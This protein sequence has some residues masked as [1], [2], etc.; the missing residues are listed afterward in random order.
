MESIGNRT[1]THTGSMFTDAFSYVLRYLFTICLALGTQLA[2]STAG[3]S[4]VQAAKLQFIGSSTILAQEE[5]EQKIMLRLSLSGEE[6]CEIDVNLRLTG[7]ATS[8]SDYE[9]QTSPSFKLRSGSEQPVDIQILDDEIGEGEETIGVLVLST[10]GEG[11]EDFDDS[12]AGITIFIEEDDELQAPEARDDP[13]VQTKIDQP[14]TIDVL[15]NDVQTP[16]ALKV[17]VDSAPANGTVAV[18]M[19]NTITYSPSVGF[20]GKDSFQYSIS[21][22][23]NASNIATVTITVGPGI[24]DSIDSGGGTTGGGA[25]EEQDP[26]PLPVAIDMS[27]T[28]GAS[29]VLQQRCR[30]LSQLSGDALAGA[31]NDISARQIPAQGSHFIE[32][33][34]TQINNIE[35]RLMSLRRGQTDLMDTRNLSIRAGGGIIPGSIFSSTL[36]EQQSTTDETSEEVV[37]RNSDEVLLG[38]DS[39]PFAMFVSGMLNTGDKEETR[40]ETG[41]DFSTNGLTIGADYRL[42]PDQ[43]IG[44]AIGYADTSSDFVNDSGSNDSDALTMALY[45]SFHVPESFFL[46]WV[47]SAGQADFETDRVIRY[48]G[49]ETRTDGSTQGDFL[50]LGLTGGLEKNIGEGWIFSPYGRLELLKLDIDGYVEKEGSGLGLI[51]D[52]QKIDS[53][54][55]TIAAEISKAYKT[56]RGSIIPSVYVEWENQLADSEREILARFAENPVIPFA[57][58]TDSPDSNY[59]NIGASITGVFREKFS[60]FASLETRAGHDDI[61]KT[62]VNVGIRIDF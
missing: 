2:L 29:S 43:V 4:D 46:D 49:F 58:T 10:L 61:R 55:L 48:P 9:L 16:A 7:S 5:D 34:S 52:Q 17:I 54:K 59:F 15:A 21:D 3:L 6:S 57:I 51:L 53:L 47:V 36:T 30:E 31:L 13:D 18:N 44:A 22:G 60:G 23:T 20:V 19:T 50:G 38:A 62:T 56:R 14:V 37:S 39:S 12:N 33:G 42:S 26:V 27:C 25:D 41:F 35:R 45:G 8:G 32:I 24:T 28:Q 1:A 40:K 11:C